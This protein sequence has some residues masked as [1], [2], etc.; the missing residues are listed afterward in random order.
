MKTNLRDML[1]FVWVFVDD[2]RPVSFVDI[3][4]VIFAGQDQ[5][6]ITLWEEPL[7]TD[8]ENIPK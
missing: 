4:G 6:H 7:I 3:K 2:G 8:F 5:S 1:D